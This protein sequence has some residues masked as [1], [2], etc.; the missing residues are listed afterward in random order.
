MA[1]CKLQ[2]QL[3]LRIIKLRLYIVWPVKKTTLLTAKH[4]SEDAED[5]FV[6]S[7]GRDVSES[8]AGQDREGEVEGRDVPGLYIRSVI[9]LVG[10]TR[11]VGQDVQPPDM[12]RQPRPLESG[13]GVED[14]GEPV[15]DHREGGHKE[16]QD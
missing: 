11:S 13:D 8:D 6:V 3:Q 12:V 2:L 15:G 9:R 16:E 7:N 4:H 1:L 14:T 10:R 5:L